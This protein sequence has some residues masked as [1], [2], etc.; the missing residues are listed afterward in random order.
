MQFTVWSDDRSLL[1]FIFKQE[2]FEQAVM[3][4]LVFQDCDHHVLGYPVNAV[5]C[6]NNSVIV[7]NATFFSFHY[8]FDYLNHIG[9][10]LRWLQEPLFRTKICGPWY[11]A[12]EVFDPVGELLCV[13]QFFLDIF[14][15]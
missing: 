7:F 14:S 4:L 12:V 6:L 11:G 3:I 9:R 15:K 5:T 13:S 2:G 10:F 8:T 1:A